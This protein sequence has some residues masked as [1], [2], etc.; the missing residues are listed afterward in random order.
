ME[1]RT[2]QRRCANSEP[3]PFVNRSSGQPQLSTNVHKRRG[4]FTQIRSNS[5]A[6]LQVGDL[7]HSFRFNPCRVGLAGT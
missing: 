1:N 4:A 3:P 6:L 7:G 5:A 2:S